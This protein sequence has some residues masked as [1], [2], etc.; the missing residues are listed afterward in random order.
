MRGS[1]LN[2]RAEVEYIVQ[3]AWNGITRVVG[4]GQ[5]VLF[6][7]STGDAWMLDPEDELALCLLKDRVP[8]PY[9]FGETDQ[10][11]IV[12]WRGRYRLEGERFTYVA[13]DQPLRVTT[14]VGYP[15]AVIR[16][17]TERLARFRENGLT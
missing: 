1:E 4:L 16:Q 11:F 6:S 15:T 3:S 7:T 5:L 17:T 8:Q 2:L 14:F 9:E 13:H 12:R 10:Q